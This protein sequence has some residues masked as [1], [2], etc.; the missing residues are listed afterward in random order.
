ML[1]A[2]KNRLRGLVA[3]AIFL[4]LT[5]YF[6]WNAVHGKSGLEAQAKEHQQL[7]TAQQQADAVHQR[8]VMWQTKVASL[9]GQAIQPDMLDEEA[10]NVLN[11]ANPG[12]LV[13][14]LPTS[15]S[16]E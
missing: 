11:L 5:Y 4:A 13:V 1:R 3:P 10:R 9:S 12:D 15:K 14:D 7:A 6:G 2:I 16:D 8:L